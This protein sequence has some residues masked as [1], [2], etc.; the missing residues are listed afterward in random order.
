MYKTN[1]KL[2]L[3]FSLVIG[4]CFWLFVDT[5]NINSIVAHIVPPIIVGLAVAVL[6]KDLFVSE[7]INGFL[8]TG[9]TLL[10]FRILLAFYPPLFENHW[11]L[12][13]LSGLFLLGIPIEELL[14]AFSV[15][16]GAGNL[17]ELIFGYVENRGNEWD[18]QNQ[19]PNK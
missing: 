2:L 4:F 11:R 14:F 18:Y 16:F 12:N 10:M 1:A 8:L 7:L 17:Y 19:S 5:L 13:N 3:I 15:G 6:R 9:L